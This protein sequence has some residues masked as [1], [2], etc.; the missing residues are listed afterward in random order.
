MLINL[1][2]RKTFS[3]VY[4]K[5]LL[6]F[7]KRVY[8]RVIVFSENDIDSI[9]INSKNYVT[10][11]INNCDRNSVKLF[12]EKDTKLINPFVFSFHKKNYFFEVLFTL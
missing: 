12:T 1:I 7:S 5:H 8:E 9:L 11:C 6:N 4:N 2:L 3:F 10:L